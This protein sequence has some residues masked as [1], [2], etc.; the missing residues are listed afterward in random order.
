MN[1]GMMKDARLELLPGRVREPAHMRQPRPE[2]V[3]NLKPVREPHDL[4]GAVAG[5]DSGFR[6]AAGRR[7]GGRARVSA[8]V[9]R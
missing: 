1:P 8:P 6:L 7:S 3:V 4:P 9:A 2:V 5:V